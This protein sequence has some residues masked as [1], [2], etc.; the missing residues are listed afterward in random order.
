MKGNDGQDHVGADMFP[1]KDVRG[2]YV[3]G[4][5]SWAAQGPRNATKTMLGAGD[6]GPVGTERFEAMREGIQLCE[7]MVFIQKALEAKQLSGA[8][9]T[10][11][12]KVLD[13]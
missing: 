5:W 10:R 9:E 3:E 11:A 1:K 7:A 4:T 6:A 2:R 8:L 13:D 12:T